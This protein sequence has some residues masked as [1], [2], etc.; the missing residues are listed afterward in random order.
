MYRRNFLKANNTIQNYG[1]KD[2]LISTER[3]PEFFDLEVNAND[4]LRS[5][6][7]AV[8]GAG[9]IGLE[10]LQKATRLNIGE[11]LV[12]DKG[13]F[14]PE[15][16]FTH[17]ITYKE[18]CS[19][20]PKAKSA[21]MYCS[22]IGTA[23]QCYYFCGPVED[24]GQ[25]DLFDVDV[26]ILCTDNLAAEIE[27]SNRCMHLGLPLIQCS[28]HGE[29]LF[30]QIRFFSNVDHNSPC[31]YC[32]YG[33]QE[34]NQLNNDTSFSCSGAIDGHQIM[35]VSETPTMSTAFLCSLAA[36]LGMTLVTRHLLKLGTTLKNSQIQYCG[37]T[38]KMIETTLR[39][40]DKCPCD[41]NPWDIR[42]ISGPLMNSTLRDL[43]LSSGLAKEGDLSNLSFAIN[44]MHFVELGICKCA[45]MR[46][47]RQFHLKNNKVGKCRKCNSSIQA[48]PFFSFSD[49]PIKTIKGHLDKPLHSI[50]VRKEVD[51]LL[52]RHDE[53]EVLFC[54]SECNQTYEMKG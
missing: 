14:S 33:K 44:K 2:Q 19:G 4:V 22:S 5:S 3:L 1:A 49:V 15:N 35:E 50:G 31:I 25:S 53:K 41:H 27:V 10:I 52:I 17:T 28:V 23:T 46:P 13:N 18:A 29:S 9:S 39:K 26:V 6:K 37:Y 32:T 12:V 36:D 30:A 38:N 43:S 7:L 51:S 34:I 45:G 11:I 16:K 20:K 48:H 42:V 8:I 54:E 21:A 47:I 24:L 40:S